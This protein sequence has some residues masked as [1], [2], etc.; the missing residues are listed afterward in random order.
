[1]ITFRGNKINS[2]RDS[3]SGYRLITCERK[4]E[5]NPGYVSAEYYFIIR[6]FRNG[7]FYIGKK[8]SS[9]ILSIELDIREDD[10]IYQSEKI[11]NVVRWIENNMEYN[12]QVERWIEKVS[13]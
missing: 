10:I 7:I 1:M 9:K 5:F 2:S 11:S 3:K 12:K 8:N 6:D 4:Q 13:K